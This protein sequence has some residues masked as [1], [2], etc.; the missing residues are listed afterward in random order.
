M[1]VFLD[2]LKNNEYIS[3]LIFLNAKDDVPKNFDLD[4]YN[5]LVLNNLYLKYQ[6]YFRTMYKDID[7]NIKLDEEQI[8]TILADEDYSLI[9]AGAGTGKTTTMVSK[10]KYLIEIKNVDPSKIL[11]MSYTKKACQELEKRLVYD[12]NLEVDIKTFH[13]LGY[14]IIKKVYSKNIPYVVDDNLKN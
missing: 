2:K 9:I 5:N 10:V 4:N 3:K 12:F 1:G 6:D 13:S 7:D 8:K 14:D 11:V